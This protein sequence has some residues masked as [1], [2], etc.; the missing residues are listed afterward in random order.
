[1]MGFKESNDLVH[2]IAV[3][4]LQASHRVGHKGERMLLKAHAKA[5]AAS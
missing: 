1:M 2:V 5:F 4:S 3:Q